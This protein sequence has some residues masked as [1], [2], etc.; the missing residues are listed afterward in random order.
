MTHDQQRWQ[1]VLNRDAGSDALF[2]YGV[3]TTGIFC[4]PSC[5][6][7]RPNP[8]NVT[9]YADSAAAELDGLRACLRCKPAS[10]QTDEAAALVRKACRLLQG[11]MEAPLSYKVLAERAGLSAAHFHRTFKQVLGVTPKQYV[12]ELRVEKLK[13]ELRHG[14]GVT[15]SLYSAGYGSSSRLYE[16]SDGNLGMTP[17]QYRKGGEGAVIAYVTTATKD[18]GRLMLAATDRGLCFLQFG[19]REAELLARLQTEYP[20]ASLRPVTEPHHIQLQSWMDSVND[21]LAGQSMTL[22]G[23][24]VDVRATA[25][26]KRVWNYLQQIPYGETRSYSRIAQE[27]GA[28][29]AT[30]AVAGACAANRVALLIPCH[31]VLRNNGE[32]GGFRWGLERKRALLDLEISRASD[33][34]QP[35]LILDRSAGS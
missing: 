2:V 24:P 35:A 1:A 32:L 6:S 27:L 4:K 21:F 13:S 30:R 33:A 12:D 22:L 8:E 11:S 9:F 34:G 5:R 23:M 26:Q 16:R 20:R 17:G 31:R 18:F 29:K 10:E 14:A 15:A 25:F 7:R 28:P 19:E 3:R